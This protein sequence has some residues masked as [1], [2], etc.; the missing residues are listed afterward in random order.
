MTS[1]G[2]QPSAPARARLDEAA[3]EIAAKRPREA[4]ALAEQAIEVDR[5][6]AA[7]LGEAGRRMLD[8]ALGFDD[9]SFGPAVA[10]TER[11][12]LDALTLDWTFPM[13]R[14]GLQKVAAVLCAVRRNHRPE[15]AE[16]LAAGN[17][18]FM[19][20]RFSEAERF[21]A[22]ATKVDPTDATA[23]KYLGNAIYNQKRLPEAVSYF[24]RATE[25]DPLDPQAFK[26]LADACLDAKDIPSMWRAIYGAIAANPRYWSAWLM[27]DR[28]L[29]GGGVAMRRFRLRP[30]ATPDFRTKTIT[31]DPSATPA[32]AAAWMAYAATWAEKGTSDMSR[33]ACE[34]EAITRMTQVIT[35]LLQN[36]EATTRSTIDPDLLLLPELA[37]RGDLRP[38]CFVLRYHESFRPE[39]EAWKQEWAR[40]TGDPIEAVQNFLVRTRMRPL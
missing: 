24:R 25:L 13:A 22:Y 40:A 16:L 10:R 1:Q 7:T 33:Y 38:L 3:R 12:L 11:V 26:F 20:L 32:T 39:L 23:H 28:L 21:F 36:D 6:C 4:F 5:A 2:G 37:K 17:Q 29:A 31:V 19:A 35:E 9:A 15:V 8:A 30:A 34:L 18:H 27:L 14:D